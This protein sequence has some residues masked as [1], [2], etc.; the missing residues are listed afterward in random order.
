MTTDHPYLHNDN[1]PPLPSQSQQT[2]FTFTITPDHLYLHNHNKPPLS[3]QWQQTTL[4]STITTDHPHLHNHNRPSSYSQSQ[5]TPVRSQSQQTTVTITNKTDHPGN[6]SVKKQTFS[7]YQSVTTSF[8]YVL[9]GIDF[10][11]ARPTQK[12]EHSAADT[13]Y[14]TRP[15]AWRQY[16]HTAMSPTEVSDRTLSLFGQFMRQCLNVF[17]CMAPV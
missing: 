17:H 9:V 13:M 1:R 2:T 11:R 6:T 15:T 5:Q 16:R 10:A 8:E 14:P 3:S 4:T 12:V 7:T